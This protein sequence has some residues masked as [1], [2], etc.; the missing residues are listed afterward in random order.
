MEKRCSMCNNPLDEWDLQEDFSFSRW[1]G[2]GSKYDLNKLDIQLCCTCFDKVLD[3]VLPK[4]KN[5]I[6]QEYEIRSENG[7]LQA[8]LVEGRQRAY[9]GGKRLLRLLSKH[10]KGEIDD[11]L[12]AHGHFLITQEEYMKEYKK[13]IDFCDEAQEDIRVEK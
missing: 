5:K 11:E 9:T 1:I 7:R 3:F 12:F 13:Y 10:L 2:Y 6:L 8:Y 4:C